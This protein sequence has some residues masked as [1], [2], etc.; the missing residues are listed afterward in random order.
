MPR[1][2]TNP[3]LFKKDEIAALINNAVIGA[4]SPKTLEQEI[5]DER[6]RKLRAYAE[7]F[8]KPLEREIESEF[9]FPEEAVYILL[10]GALF[11]QM[12]IAGIDSMPA[13]KGCPLCEAKRKNSKH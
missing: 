12:Q 13:A 10:C 11:Y 2:V 7:A 3:G 8:I 4:K 6:L 9:L 5:Q 1:K